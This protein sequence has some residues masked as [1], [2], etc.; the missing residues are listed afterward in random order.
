MASTLCS[1]IIQGGVEGIVRPR[2]DGATLWTELIWTDRPLDGRS[3]D[4]DGRSVDLDG[5]DLD[6]ASIGRTERRLGRTEPWLGRSALDDGRTEP[7]SQA[8]KRSVQTSAPSVHGRWTDGA[9]FSGAEALRPNDAPSVQVD[10]RSAR[11]DVASLDGAAPS[12]QEKVPSVHGRWT[13]GSVRP[14]GRY[15]QP[16]DDGRHPPPLLKRFK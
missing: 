4:L 2:T 11:L 8:P 13:E 3:A 16:L 15:V 12:V 9:R 1:G 7:D 14:D 10:G 5:A 6:G